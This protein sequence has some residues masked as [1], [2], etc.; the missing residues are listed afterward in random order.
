MSRGNSLTS[1]SS[2]A[3]TTRMTTRT[4]L[5]SAALVVLLAVSARG[6]SCIA[7]ARA[8]LGDCRASCREDLQVAKDA[9]LNRDHACVEVCRAQ[10]EECRDATGFDADIAACDAKLEADVATCRALYPIGTDRATCIDDAQIAGFQCRDQAREDN[11]PALVACRSQ[12]RMCATAC[13]PIDP[14]V[15]P[16]DAG[17]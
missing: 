4:G 11:R 5:L 12:F 10:R 2:H 16:T 13:P 1:A 7:S 6:D 15:T 3:Q 9:C 14:T 17:V 8:E